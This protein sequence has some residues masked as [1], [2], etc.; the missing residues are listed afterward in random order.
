MHDMMSRTAMTWTKQEINDSIIFVSDERE[1]FTFSLDDTG[2]LVTLDGY[3]LGK[4]NTVHI[5]MSGW[6]EYWTAMT[7]GKTQRVTH[8]N[9]YQDIVM[10]VTRD[11]SG[12]LS[13]YELDLASNTTGEVKIP[14]SLVKQ[15]T[16]AM[17]SLG[18]AFPGDP[19]Q[20]AGGRSDSLQEI[21][22]PR[23]H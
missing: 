7:A 20:A 4:L 1:T 14:A 21:L 13:L 6:Q 9:R 22:T 19:L 3:Y 5:P 8:E 18:V 17:K 16:A 11:S 12:D 15:L 10:T 2:K 23:R